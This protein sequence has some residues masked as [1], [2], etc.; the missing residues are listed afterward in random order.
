MEFCPVELTLK[1]IKKQWTVLILKEFFN[2][3]EM[4]FNEILKKIDYLSNKV[5]AERLKELIEEQ[6]IVK[7]DINYK[8]IYS[9]TKIGE[10]LKPVL[11]SLDKWGEDHKKLK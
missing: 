1:I 9:L 3:N 10:S 4:T 7:K 2:Q 8:T 6:V 11:D 5:L